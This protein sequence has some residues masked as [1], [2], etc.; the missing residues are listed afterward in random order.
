[1][2]TQNDNTGT[3]LAP[4]TPRQERQLAARDE[5]APGARPS[6]IVP[7]NFL[8]VQ[9]M[10]QALAGAGIVPKA[11]KDRPADMSIVIMCGAEVGI[12]PMAALRLYTTW[13]GVPRLMAEGIRAVIV[14]H[15]DCEY[16]EVQTCDDNQS[17]W[18]T[19]R[20]GRPE[21]SVTWTM[22]RAQKAGLTTKP[23]WQNYQQD[24]LNARCSMQLGRIVWPD[25]VAGMVSREEAMDGDFID[26]SSTESRSPAFAPL[27]AQKS[28]PVVQGSN[29]AEDP[30]LVGPQANI[31]EAKRRAKAKPIEAKSTERP[32]TP[33]ASSAGSSGGSSEASTS[34]PSSAST[35]PASTSSESSA[36][37]LDAAVAKVEAK[38]D[39]TPAPGGGGASAEPATS[40]ST[41]S[42]SSPTST[43]SGASGDQ[44][45]ED[46]GFGGGDGPAATPLNQLLKEF[47][48]WLAEC[49][50]RRELSAGLQKWKAWSIEL[51]KAGNNDFLKAAPGV[52]EG[53]GTVE[54]STAYA[55]RKGEVGE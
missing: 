43:P 34:A 36:S 32:T 35:T 30:K 27:P 18:V 31:D 47:H 6:A 46:D 8:E 12:P 17:T 20:R 15:P 4:M 48:E 51:A 9:Q 16:F 14:S 5:M 3:A 44:E 2:T 28:E 49:K 40:T 45:P 52:P 25:V 42:A 55:K 21:K 24:M 33:P 39:P 11:F 37:K 22:A 10:C 23:V 53:K 19:K 50:N 13:D 26:A 54:M 1:V 41:A 7:R 38:R 29:I